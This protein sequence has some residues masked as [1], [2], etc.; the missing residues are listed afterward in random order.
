MLYDIIVIGGGPAGLTAALY[1]RRA[2]RTA[3]ILEKNALGG[4]ITWSPKVENYPGMPAVSG[5]EFA[6]KLAAQ[7]LDSGAELELDEVTKIEPVSGGF[8]VL[9]AF[10][11]EYAARAV[12]LALGARPRRLGLDGEQELIGAGVSFCAVCDGEFYK[13]QDVAVCGGGNSALQEA[14]YLSSLC[15]AV[16][17]IH[18]RDEFRGDS[19]L[20]QAVKARENIR[21]MLSM[22]VSALKTD[23]GAEPRLVGL[24]LSG[25]DG[26]TMTL[27]VECLFE[28]I[29]HEPESEIAAGLIKLDESGYADSGE[30]CLTCVPGVFVAGDLRV[31]SVRQLTTATSDGAVAALAACS[32][33]DSFGADN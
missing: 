21:L 33:L 15:R 8:K 30:D 6:D 31:K 22:K 13:D 16:Y 7:V 10:G 29:G 12:I 19:A 24:T 25:A 5:L 2:G 4:Q 23:G 17:L 1:A 14:L 27:A 28:A 32:Y 3:L 18:R 26:D 20:V 11:G 9:T